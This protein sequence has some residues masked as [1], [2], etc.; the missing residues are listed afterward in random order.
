MGIRKRFGMVGAKI[1]RIDFVEKIV[2]I[3]SQYL[4]LTRVILA[5]TGIKSPWIDAKEMEFRSR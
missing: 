2:A 4:P 1:S 5:T 3:S